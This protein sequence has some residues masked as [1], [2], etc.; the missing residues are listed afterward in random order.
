[1]WRALSL[2][3]SLRASDERPRP[4]APVGAFVA[5]M[6][7]GRRAARYQEARRSAGLA[8]GLKECAACGHS[9]TFHKPSCNCE[10][11]ACGCRKFV[12]QS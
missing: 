1:M 6:K 9:E 8:Q 12:E 3:R 5:A 7:V 10:S 2:R 11:G 4:L